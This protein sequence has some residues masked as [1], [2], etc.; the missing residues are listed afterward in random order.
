MG[1]PF[2]TRLWHEVKDGDNVRTYSD[3]MDLNEQEKFLKELKVEPEWLEDA[4]QNYYEYEKD[5]DTYKLWAEGKKSLT[6]KAMV[7]GEKKLAG[8]AA[9][10]MGG[11]TEGLWSAIKSAVEGDISALVDENAAPQETGG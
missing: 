6:L 5:G 7:I 10:E 9:W 11:E 8:V 4:G 1:V 2:Y 3:S